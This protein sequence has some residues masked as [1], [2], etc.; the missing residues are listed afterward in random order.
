ME[1]MK[2]RLTTFTL[3]PFKKAPL[4]LAPLTLALSASLLFGA[5]GGSSS[6]SS[7][8]GAAGDDSNVTVAVQESAVATEEP[9][10]TDG[11]AAASPG[12]VPSIPDDVRAAL[13]D[14]LAE[15]GVEIPEGGLGAGLGGSGAG[16]GGS[17][18]EGFDPTKLQAAMQACQD[19][20]PEG[21]QLPG[22]GA[23][24]GGPDISAFITCLKDN[25]VVVPD[26]ATIAQL[27]T[28]DPAFGAA[29]ETC[30]PLLPQLPG[31]AGAGVPTT[32]AA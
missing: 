5:C 8:G 19:K 13:T 32:V 16:L 17:L 15:N 31:A 12:G 10:A 29:S 22:A 21:I 2:S 9:A 24:A 28:G 4:T 20:L 30:R 25:G 18:P 11:G 14:C 7:S 1:S 27:P 26:N 23:G 6:D 3:A